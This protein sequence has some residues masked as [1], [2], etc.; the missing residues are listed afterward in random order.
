MPSK[1]LAEPTAR[2]I[3]PK[4]NHHLLTVALVG[5]VNELLAVWPTVDNPP[6]VPALSHD[7]VHI[8]N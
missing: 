5:G 1:S 2:D 7:R 6:P 8:P 4:Y 3:L